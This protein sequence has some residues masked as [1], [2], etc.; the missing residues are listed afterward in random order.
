MSFLRVWPD[1]EP[2]QYREHRR[3]VGGQGAEL[4]LQRVDAVLE[5]VQL[6]AEL[7]GEVS[8]ALQR[9]LR[10][11]GRGGA[12]GHRDVDAPDPA[13]VGPPQVQRPPARLPVDLPG[14]SCRGSPAE[15]NVTGRS[16]FGSI[17]SRTCPCHG[18]GP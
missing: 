10:L 2:V 17:P 13:V 14:G 18:S 7:G 5:C 3:V 6:P 8:L 4:G 11:L 9:R 15:T 16:R 1:S 12:D